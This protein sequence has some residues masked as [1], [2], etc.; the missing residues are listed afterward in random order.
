[1]N[2]AAET[3]EVRMPRMEAGLEG[4]KGPMELYSFEGRAQRA[5]EQYRIEDPALSVTVKPVTIR[6]GGVTVRMYALT[7]RW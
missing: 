7:Y 3:H 2:T 1:M 4:D 5:A 6:S